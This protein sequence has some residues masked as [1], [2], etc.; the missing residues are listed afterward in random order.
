VKRVLA[1]CLLAVVTVACNPLADDPLGVTADKLGEIR[2]GTMVLRIVASTRGGDDTGFEIGGPFSLPEGES[3][4][5]AELAYERLGE[6]VSEALVFV[7]TG[8]AAFL[9]VDGQAYELPPEQVSTLV[10]SADPGDEGPFDGLDVSAWAIEPKASE[11]DVVDGVETE[12]VRADLDVVAAVNDLFDMARDF[13]AAD[14]PSVKGDEAERLRRAVETATL[15]LVTGKE[16]RFLRRLR[17]AIELGARAPEDLDPALRDLL[18]VRFKLVLSIS[19]PNQEIDVPAPS[20]PLPY[21]S[22]VG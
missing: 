6:E 18:G 11:G 21:E 17:V 7:S 1:T 12:V 15:E 13:G 4:P 19:D 2:S 14:L 5:E 8:E 20:N 22:L 9:E 3:L 10:G 16:D